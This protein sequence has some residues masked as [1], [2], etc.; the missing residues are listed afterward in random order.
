MK[1]IILLWILLA[2]YVGG[3][4]QPANDNACGAIN[5]SVENLGC[6]PSLIYSYTGATITPGFYGGCI[7]GTSDNDVWYKVTVPANG[8]FTFKMDAAPSESQSIIASWYS[9]GNCANQLIPFQSNNGIFCFFSLPFTGTALNLTPGSVTYL[10]VYKPNNPTGT[11]GSFKMCVSNNNVLADDPCNAGFMDIEAADPL[12]QTCLPIRELSYSNASLTA[13]VPNPTCQSS[14]FNEIRDVWFKIRVPN[15]GKFVL[16]ADASN[17][18]T[19]LAVYSATTCNGPFTQVGCTYGNTA[20]KLNSSPGSILYARVNRWS[21]SPIPSSTVKICVADRNDL[22]AV[23]NS[24]GKVGIGVDSPFTKLHVIGSGYF[25]DKIIAGGD[26]ETRGNLIVQGNIINRTA[27]T[28]LSGSLTLDSLAFTNRLGNHLSLYGGFAPNHYGLGIQ[29]GLMQIYA[30]AAAANIAFGFGSSNNFTERARIINQGEYGMTMKGRLQLSTGTQSAGLW[31]TNTANSANDAFIGMA[32]D[33]RVGFFGGTGSQWALTMNTTTGNVGIGLNTANPTRPLSFPASLGEKIL[34]YPGGAGEVGIG[35]YGN[36]LRLH[37]DNPGAAVSFGTQ[38][39]AGVFTQ[40]GRFQISAPYALFVNG[41]IWANGSTYASDAR[42]KQNIS[43]ITSPLQKLLQLNGVEYEMRTDVF[44][45]NNFQQ[46]RQIG[47]LAQNVEKVVPE[48]VNEMD[49]YKGVDYARLVP[50]LIE[51]IKEQ[52]LQIK[53]RNEQINKIQT[54]L[55]E[56]KLLF[57]SFI[58]K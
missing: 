21:S 36:E 6:E 13:G 27:N 17:P 19:V 56:L 22:P 51:S 24:V 46:G 7:N 4:A 43:T 15:S 39:N 37:A 40:A 5:I 14:N 25:N 49:G 28:G 1:K 45:K 53:N 2:I 42:F 38:T 8:Q 12:G 31:L 54:Q 48:A 41:S 26:I 29:G 16:N 9:D 20:L 32:A 57:E 52:Q 11:S 10:R 23:N 44:H 47:L 50:L 33:D 58:N 3:Y 30:D 35:V 55:D 34:L 18:T